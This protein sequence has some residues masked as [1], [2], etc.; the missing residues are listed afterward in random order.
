MPLPTLGDHTLRNG[1]TYTARVDLKV[2]H[3]LTR[4]PVECERATSPRGARS[5][6]HVWRRFLCLRACRAHGSRVD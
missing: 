4:V 2:G 1:A 5:E 6:R 3:S